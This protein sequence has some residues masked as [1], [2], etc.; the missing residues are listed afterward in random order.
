MKHNM[1]YK[2][3]PKKS[4]IFHLAFCYCFSANIFKRRHN[5]DKR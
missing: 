1:K 2:S 5:M 4:D 3:A